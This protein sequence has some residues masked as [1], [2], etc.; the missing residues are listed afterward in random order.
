MGPRAAAEVTL[1]EVH[2]SVHVDLRES[3]GAVEP[4]ES[5]AIHGLGG[6]PGTSHI[7]PYPTRCLHLGKHLGFY[8]WV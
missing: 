8:T 5:A 4:W 2:G 3:A 7:Q 1:R 6:R